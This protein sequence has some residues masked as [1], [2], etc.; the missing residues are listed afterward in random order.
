MGFS[1]K[2]VAVN[3]RARYTATYHDLHGRQRPAGTFATRRAADRAWQRAEVLLGL[4]WAGDPARGRRTFQRY[5][6]DTWFPHHEVEATTRQR[7]WYCLR[8]HIVPDFGPMKMAQ[9]LPEHVREWVTTLKGRGASPATIAQNMVILSG[10]FTTALN[11]Q[12]T[13]LHPC[14]GVRTPPV[15]ARPY[16]IITPEQFTA[17]HDALTDPQWQLLAETA[18]ETGLR[19]G[20]AD[21][22]ARSRHRVRLPHADRQPRRRPG[23]TPVPPPRRQV[24][25]QGLPQGP[26]VPP[27]QAHTSP[28]NCRRTSRSAG[29]DGM[30]WCS[31][32]LNLTGLGCESPGWWWALKR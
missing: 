5:V 23:V 18:V 32:R 16:T 26:G 9:I 12:I 3:G 17:V 4:G 27:P 31:R 22:A 28:P 15:P 25:G 29:W 2:R 14:K 24:P 7:Y 19:W 30:T 1:R 13:S 10:I 8:K 11:D 6:E 21:R 20:G